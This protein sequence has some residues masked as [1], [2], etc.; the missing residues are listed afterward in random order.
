MNSFTKHLLHKV[1]SLEL[2]FV[3]ALSKFSFNNLINSPSFVKS[4]IIFSEFSIFSE[5]FKISGE[6]NLQQLQT[7]LE[8]FSSSN[9]SFSLYR[10]FPINFKV[11]FCEFKFIS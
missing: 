8:G 6:G 2:L 10:L 11:S 9:V 3:I 5:N 4:S 7:F 1:F